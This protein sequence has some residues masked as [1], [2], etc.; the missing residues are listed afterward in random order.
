MDGKR[1][2]KREITGSQKVVYRPN[3]PVPI[4]HMALP[5]RILGKSPI[6]HQVTPYVAGELPIFKKFSI[7]VLKENNGTALLAVQ[8][9]QNGRS[10]ASALSGRFKEWDC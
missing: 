4:P 8:G 9:S 3:I 1:N 6:R 2:T 7:L 5:G 10:T